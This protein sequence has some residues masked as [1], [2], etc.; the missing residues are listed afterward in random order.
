MGAHHGGLAVTGEGQGEG[1]AADFEPHCPYCIPRCIIQLVGVTI[2]NGEQQSDYQRSVSKCHAHGASASAVAAIGLDGGAEQCQHERDYKHHQLY[3]YP[4]VATIDAYIPPGAL[5]EYLRR[6]RF[7]AFDGPRIGR[8][9]STKALVPRCQHHSI[10]RPRLSE[11]QHP[12]QCHY[13]SAEATTTFGTRP[14]PYREALGVRAA[15]RRKR[16]RRTP[17]REGATAFGEYQHAVR[18]ELKPCPFRCRAILHA[19]LLHPLPV[20]S[21][22]FLSISCYPLVLFL[23]MIICFPLPSHP[24][25][26]NL[27]PSLLTAITN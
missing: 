11:L 20:H 23:A 27:L 5:C 8:I 16:Y 24:Y 17:T 7:E 25:I 9:Q 18:P 4:F 21:P 13:S 6:S 14:E 12:F 2:I 26:H 22:T 19:L 15:K 10:P 1:A 3:P